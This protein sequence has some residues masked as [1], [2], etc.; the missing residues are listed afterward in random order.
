MR[1][2][3]VQSMQ[4][5][6]QIATSHGHATK[7]LFDGARGCVFSV[8]L[9]SAPRPALSLAPNAALSHLVFRNFY[10]A[11]LRLVQVNRDGTSVVLVEAH[12]LMQHI[13]YEDDAQKWHLLRLDKVRT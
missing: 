8:H 3:R 12:P 9:Q 13:H 7:A 11:V 1:I 5:H 4:E 6:L 2:G 10:A